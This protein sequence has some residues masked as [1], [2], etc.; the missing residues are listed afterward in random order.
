MT[1]TR[2][3]SK[4]NVL[5]SMSPWPASGIEVGPERSNYTGGSTRVRNGDMIWSRVAAIIVVWLEE[6]HPAV[7]AD[8]DLCCPLTVVIER[9]GKVE[10]VDVIV[11]E[12]FVDVPIGRIEPGEGDLLHDVASGTEVGRWACAARGQGEAQGDDQ[13]ERRPGHGTSSITPLHPGGGTPEF[14]ILRCAEGPF[15]AVYGLLTELY[16]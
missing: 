5:R 7:V 16:I 2:F 9:K 10:N 14:G 12:A 4:P 8:R 6:R 3:G 15:F 11:A 13:G 1:N